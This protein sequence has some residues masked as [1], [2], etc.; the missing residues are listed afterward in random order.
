F[1]CG[2]PYFPPKDGHFVF[3]TPDPIPTSSV[4]QG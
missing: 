2:K 1:D 3:K 4:D